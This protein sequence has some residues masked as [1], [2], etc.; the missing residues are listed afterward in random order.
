MAFQTAKEMK[1]MQTTENI[2]LVDLNDQEIGFCEKLETHEKGAL[3]R[4]FSIFIH[5]GD[6]MLI[7]KRALTKYHSGGLWANACCSHPRQGESLE[8]AVHRRLPEEANIDCPLTELFSFTYRTEF[9]NGLTEFEFDHVFLGEYTGTVH[10]NPEEASECRWI[11]FADL[12][13][14][15]LEHPEQFASWFLIAAPKVMKM[16]QGAD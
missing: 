3:H 9:S 4:A 1:Q 11:S 16:I 6:Q 15:M 8:E 2:I 14:E 5:D 13:Q 7:Q 10:M 12:K